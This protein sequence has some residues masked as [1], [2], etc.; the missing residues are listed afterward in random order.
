M[1]VISKDPFSVGM[2]E[3]GASSG[4]TKHAKHKLNFDY[5]VK[6]LNS[7]PQWYL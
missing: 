3:L 5:K 7:L 4:F 6:P 2:L 1:N